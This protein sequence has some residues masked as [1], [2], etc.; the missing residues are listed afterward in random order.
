MFVILLPGVWC[1]TLT[2]CC[3]SL[4]SSSLGSDTGGSVRNP[5]ALCGLVGLKPS[6]G[7]LSR[8]GLVPLVNSMDVPGLM[9]RSVADAALVFSECRGRGALESQVFM[10]YGAL[11]LVVSGDFDSQAFVQGWVRL[12]L[13]K[14]SVCP[15]QMFCGLLLKND[16][17]FELGERFLKLTYP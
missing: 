11:R 12:G 7:L 4:L 9:T 5:A 15:C 17:F 10:N 8:H 2:R 14:P 6:Y 13:C 1:P 3:P 16:I